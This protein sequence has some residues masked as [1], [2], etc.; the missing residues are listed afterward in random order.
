M[1]ILILG[2]TDD[3]H[4]VHMYEYLRKH[5]QDV[6]LFD[7]SWFPTQM[8]ISFDPMSGNGWFRLPGGRVVPFDDVQSVYW[9]CYNSIGAPALPD[10][11]QSFIASNDSRS[12]FESVLMR[13]PAKWVNGWDGFRLHQTKPAQLAMVAELGVP[14]PQT[15]LSN[16]PQ[17]IRE[18]ASRQQRCVFKPVQGGAHTRFVTSRH[19]T[20]ENLRN[21]VY[22]PVTL[23]E[24]IPGT[25]IRVFVARQQVLACEV[26][27]DAIDF[28]DDI[29]AVIRP[30]ELP[31]AIAEQAILIAKRLHL[32]WTG[33]D[34]RLRPDGQYVFLEANP[35]PMFI[36]FEE[37][38]GLPL[39]QSLGHLLMDKEQ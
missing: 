26:A 8:Q 20:D 2:S 30:H 19:L 35:S 16:D 3:E 38:S 28:R 23:Q 9:R 18:F 27:T 12:L 15:I 39:T 6:E 37:A 21:L 22:A 14:V 10:A 34:Y 4:A 25:N 33:M 5:K 11:E 24:E 17:A 7:S 32:L 13:L 1:T 36:G 29:S 31:A